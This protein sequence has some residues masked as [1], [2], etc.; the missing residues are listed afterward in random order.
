MSN[1]NNNLQDKYF[2]TFVNN[3]IYAAVY[4]I[5]GKMYD[6]FITDYDAFTFTILKKIEGKNIE[7]LVY[8]HAVTVITVFIPGFHDKDKRK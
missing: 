1:V 2:S 6:G 4:L 8:K 3:K 5:N 7:S